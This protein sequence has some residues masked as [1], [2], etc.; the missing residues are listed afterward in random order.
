MLFAVTPAFSA[1]NIFYSVADTSLLEVSPVNN[2]GGFPGMNAG[3]TQEY[4]RNRALFRFDLST[5]PTNTAI[6][7]AAVQLTA[8]RQPG[9]GEP[10]NNAA[11]GLHRMLVPWGEGDKNPASQPGKGLPA[12]AG[13]ATW[14]HA[15]YSTNAWSAPGGSSGVDFS[16]VE[17]AFQTVE[18]DPPTLI[19]FSSNPEM[20]ADVTAW[21]QHP[22]GNFGWIL[23]CTDE[24]TQ[25]T[26]RR[27]GSREDVDHQPMLILDY[28]IPPAL[29]IVKTNATQ[30]QLHF[31]AWAGHNYDV[32]YRDS[33][34]T[35]NWLPLTNLTAV[36][37]NYSAVVIDSVS[38]TQRF[39]RVNAH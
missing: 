34:P 12:S 36:E 22:S 16:S 31:T 28:L 8:T 23:L 19:E 18:L 29:Q 32:L 39:Y 10:I 13:E 20:V 38:S 1:S 6:F 35:G 37:T 9:P 4:K 14:D 7:S 25:S 3:V 24:S 15:F 11:Y 5:L 27:F 2:L 17:S 30:T 26:A 33:L 21:I